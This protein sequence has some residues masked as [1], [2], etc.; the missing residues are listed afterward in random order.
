MG[1]LLQLGGDEGRHGMAAPLLLLDLGHG[2]GGRLQVLAHGAG[3]V[4]VADLDVLAVLLDEVRGE[5]RRLGG[6]EVRG[7]RPVLLGDEGADLALAVADELEGDGLDPPRAQP[8]PHLLPEDRAHLVADEAIQD[9]PRLLGVDLL[10]VDLARVLEGEV[11][12]LLGDLVEDHALELL[13]APHAQGFREVPAD[14]L[15]L[16]VRVGGQED[17]VRVLGRRLELVEDLL[18]SGQDLVFGGEPLLDVHAQLLLGQ[19]ADVSHGG[20][21]GEVLPEIFVDRLRLGGR[22]HDHEV[23]GHVAPVSGRPVST[24]KKMTPVSMVPDEEGPRQAADFV[25]KLQSTQT[26]QQVWR[27]KPAPGPEVLQAGGDIRA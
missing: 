15:A 19:V 23:L 17:R 18:A 16:A 26:G 20:L 2:E 1:F 27:F 13:L 22:L 8:A 10:L 25:L 3:L 4:A 14:G 6:F 21:H 24:S 11:D 5:G 7:H 12:G 9:A